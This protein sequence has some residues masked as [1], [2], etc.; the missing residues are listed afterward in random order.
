MGNACESCR[1]IYC[2]DQERMKSEDT[3]EVGE[4]NIHL[5]TEKLKTVS[6]YDDYEETAVSSLRSPIK[7]KDGRIYTG[8]TQGTIRHGWGI[9]VWPDGSRYEG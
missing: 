4:M 3:A 6:D 2:S 9:Q 7:L 1:T 8:D 5:Q